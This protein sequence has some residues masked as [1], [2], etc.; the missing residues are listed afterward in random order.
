[1]SA[2]LTLSPLRGSGI[3]RVPDPRAPKL[4]LGLTLAAAPQLRALQ[5]IEARA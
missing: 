4:A 2:G 5:E 1:M 3:S